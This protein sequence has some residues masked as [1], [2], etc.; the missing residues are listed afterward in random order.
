MVLSV[1]KSNAGFT[2]TVVFSAASFPAFT[3]CVTVRGL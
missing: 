1:P 2:S 3:D